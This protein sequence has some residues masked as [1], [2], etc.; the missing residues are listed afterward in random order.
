MSKEYSR[1]SEYLV[2]EYLLAVLFF[3]FNYSSTR[4]YSKRVLL[5]A[6]RH[7]M[8]IYYFFLF[9]LNDFHVFYELFFNEATLKQK[10]FIL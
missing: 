8:M 5:E 6:S 3:I 1:V 4:E 10:I 7:Y 9:I 2:L